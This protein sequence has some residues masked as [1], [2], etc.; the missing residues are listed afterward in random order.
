MAHLNVTYLGLKLRNP[1]IVSSSG[2]TAS[3]MKLQRLEES[4]AGAVVLKS[5]FEEQILNEVTHLEEYTGYTE[6]ADYLQAYLEDNYLSK[7]LAL[8][9]SAKESLSIPVIASLC[10]VSNGDWVDYARKIEEAGADA[11]ELNIFLMPVTCE[12]ESAAIEQ[13]YLDIVHEVVSAVRLPVS[14]K[15]GSRFTNLLNIVKGIEHRDAKG[16]V[17]FNRFY[18]PD[19]NINALQLVEADIFS[20]PVELRNSIRGIAMASSKCSRLDIAASTGVHSGEDAVKVLLAGAAAV[21][22]CSTVYKHGLGVI[23]EINTFIEKWM[24]KQK[25]A[26]IQDF[27]GRLN[28]AHV[29]NPFAF[30]RAQFMK[31]FQSHHE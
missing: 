16:V 4:G 20:S 29:S 22:I 12:E 18:E 8:I 13:S 17:M 6:A 5:V 14:V 3:L 2:L 25:F 19:I 31:Y 1:L 7:H 30:E 9:K 21:E 27:K 24:L 26:T 10:C 11:L 28:Y 23:A 15:L